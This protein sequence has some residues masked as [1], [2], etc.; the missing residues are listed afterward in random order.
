MSMDKVDKA[1]KVAKK[2]NAIVTTGKVAK[3]TKKLVTPLIMGSHVIAAGTNS[4]EED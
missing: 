2:D 1:A 3:K 4:N